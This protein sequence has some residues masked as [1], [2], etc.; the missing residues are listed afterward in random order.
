MKSVQTVK[1]AFDNAPAKIS[2]I[3]IDDRWKTDEN[4]LEYITIHSVHKNTT[5]MV[6]SE[7][8]RPYMYRQQSNTP[9]IYEREI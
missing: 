3:E 5:A 9:T 8:S 7:Y 4:A 2:A 1:V 6:I